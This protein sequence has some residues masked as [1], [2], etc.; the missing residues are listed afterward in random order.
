MKKKARP[1]KDSLLPKCGMQD[2][3]VHNL[4]EVNQLGMCTRLLQLL[5]VS[6]EVTR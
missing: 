4:M 2:R 3:V 6:T 5:P 1:L